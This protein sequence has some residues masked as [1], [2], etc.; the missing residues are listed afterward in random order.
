VATLQGDDEHRAM[1]VLRLS[2]QDTL[3]KAESEYRLPATLQVGEKT[4]RS[5]DQPHP[6]LCLAALALALLFLGRDTARFSAPFGPSHDGFNAALY[7]TGGRAILEEGLV[8]SRLGA[9]STTLSGD[10]V[11]YA[12]HPPLVYLADAV[13]MAF[14]VS[15]ETAS[16]LPAVASSLIV[17]WLLVH[18]LTA[19]GLDSGAAGLGLLVAFSSPMFL[20]FGAVTEPHVLGLAPMTALTMLWQRLRRRSATAVLPLAC[21]AAIATLTSWQA[22]AFAA[23]IGV[24]LLIVERRRTAAAAVLVATA[25]SVVLVALWVLWAY[26]GDLRE[27]AER[28][29][30]RVG[31]GNAGRVSFRQMIGAQMRYFDDLFP[32]GIFMVVPLSTVG[33]VDRRTR[34][35]VAVSLGTVLGYALLFKNG[36]YDHSYWAYCILL[37]L[38]LGAAAALDNLSQWVSRYPSP[39]ATRSLLGTALIVVIGLFLQRPSSEQQQHRYAAEIGSQASALRWPDGQQYLYHAFGGRGPTDLLPWLRFYARREPLGVDGPQSVP[40][41]QIMLRVVDGRL[42]TVPGER[43][44]EPQ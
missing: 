1:K 42:L 26:G 29:V 16:R 5:P 22:A 2:S 9:S 36:A 7:G 39:R 4:L 12:H 34:P 13:A 43:P 44:G 23:A 11:V 33:L 25:V 10:R 28:A 3:E 14:P 20:I 6:A 37:P 17:L 41:G 21:A 35:L 18:L 40:R 30:H 31:V 27:F 19:S 24:V 8:A 38:A 15:A 32:F